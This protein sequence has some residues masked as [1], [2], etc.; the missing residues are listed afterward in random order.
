[1][2]DERLSEIAKYS[3]CTGLRVAQ[4]L[5]EVVEVLKVVEDIDARRLR[6]QRSIFFEKDAEP[7]FVLVRYTGRLLSVAR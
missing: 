2:T 3:F 1:M 7:K 5:V 6:H 4:Y